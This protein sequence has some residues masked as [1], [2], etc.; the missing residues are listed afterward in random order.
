MDLSKYSE[1][2]RKLRSEKL[3]RFE[4][5]KELNSM[6]DC[7]RKQTDRIKWL[8]DTM[9]KVRS[10]KKVELECLVE[11]INMLQWEDSENKKLLQEAKKRFAFA[12]L[13]S[14]VINM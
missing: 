6:E 9:D 10:S 14:F 1:M 4:R 13:Q 12:P 3:K 7:I 2:H 5:E 8:E 11:Q